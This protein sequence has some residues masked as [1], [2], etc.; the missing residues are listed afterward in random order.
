MDRK[1]SLAMIALRAVIL[2]TLAVFANRL[3]LDAAHGQLS[4]WSVVVIAI[5]AGLAAW[6]AWGLWG[7]YARSA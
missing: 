6:I 5:M 7:R 3:I 2:A 4:V 1:P